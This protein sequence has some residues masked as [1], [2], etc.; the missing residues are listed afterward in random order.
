MKASL[1]IA[2]RLF[3]PCALSSVITYASSRT[4]LQGGFL[5]SI[6]FFDKI[7]HFFL[8]GLLAT[9]L[10][11]FRGPQNLDIKRACLAVAATTVFGISDECHQFLRPDRYFELA[12]ILADFSGSVV[13]VLVYR[14]WRTYRSV[15][16]YDLV[17]IKFA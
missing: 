4:G 3:W 6:P 1:S 7:A 16:E 9:L 5:V 15:L 8:F 11:R 12:D 14:S 10:Y 13:A 17:R 2:Y